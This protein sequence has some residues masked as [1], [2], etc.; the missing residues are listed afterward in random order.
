MPILDL[1]PFPRDFRDR[2]RRG[3]TLANGG[4]ML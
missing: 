1:S 2:R 4:M 3:A